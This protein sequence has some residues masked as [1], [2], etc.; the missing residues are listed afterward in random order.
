MAAGK[1][2]LKTTAV[3]QMG[4]AGIPVYYNMAGTTVTL[5]PFADCRVMMVPVLVDGGGHFI[6]APLDPASI[7][8]LADLVA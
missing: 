7:T 1:N 8:G 4:A 6:L 5:T 2:Y 3:P